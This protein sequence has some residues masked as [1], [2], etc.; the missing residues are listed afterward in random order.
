MFW[1]SVHL[2]QPD[3]AKSLLENSEILQKIVLNILRIVKIKKGEIEKNMIKSLSRRN[4]NR[5]IIS[6]QSKTIV[7]IKQLPTLPNATPLQHKKTEN[8]AMA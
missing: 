5:A 3:M 4:S 1:L 2:D 6:R 7:N 8:P